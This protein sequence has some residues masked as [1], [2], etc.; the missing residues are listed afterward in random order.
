MFYCNI[1]VSLFMVLSIF[2]FSSFVLRGVSVDVCCVWSMSAL[3]RCIM[4]VIKRCFYYP[5]YQDGRPFIPMGQ[6]HPAQTPTSAIL[7]GY[8]TRA[9]R[10]CAV[11]STRPHLGVDAR[12]CGA[13]K[14]QLHRYLR[15]LLKIMNTFV[16]RIKANISVLDVINYFL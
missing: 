3:C 8:A 15:D 7:P 12:S 9:H 1:C 6:A 11:A 16:R 5:R 10:A 4:C 2:C 13:D 14:R